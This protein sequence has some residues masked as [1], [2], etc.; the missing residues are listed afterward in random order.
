M[1]IF[2]V[3]AT[4]TY[5]TISSAITAAPGNND[6][7]IIDPGTYNEGVT[8]DKH[9]SLLG[10]TFT[11]EN[12]DVIINAPSSSYPINI[13]YAP[14]SAKSVFIEG[15]KLTRVLSTWSVDFLIT[16]SNSNLSV[17]FNRCII[18]AGTNEYSLDPNNMALNKFYVENCYLQRGY[19]HVVYGDWTNISESVISKTETNNAY[20]CYLCT[21]TPDTLDTV[22][23]PTN[24][25][26]PAYGSYYNSIPTGPLFDPNDWANRFRI[27]V[28]ISKVDEDLTDFPVCITLA[29]GVGISNYDATDIF[30]ELISISGTK[31]IAVVDES[32]NQLYTEIESW[33]WVNEKAV[34]WAKV[35]NI[36]SISGTVLYLYY[37]STTSGNTYYIGDT[38]DDAATYVWTNNYA[39]VWHMAQDPS[40]GSNCVLDSTYYMRHFTPNGSMDSNDLVAGKIGKAIEFDGSNDYLTSSYNTN[41]LPTGP[42]TFE[43]IIKRDGTQ[44]TWFSGYNAGDTE[45]WDMFVT[46][47]LRWY[48]F[49][50]DNAF[51][52]TATITGSEWTQTAFVY[53]YD[54]TSLDYYVNGSF[55]SSHTVVRSLQ[56]NANLSI[57]ARS[58]GSSS[59][60]N[61][62][63]YTGGVDE[64]RISLCERSAAWIKANYYSHW[65]DFITFG[66]LPPPLPPP[67][68]ISGVAN[69]WVSGDF[70]FKT[71][72]SGIGVYSVLS[73]NLLGVI[74][75]TPR[76]AGAVWANDDYL[77]ISTF[78]SGV[79]K[80]PMSSISGA[81][82]NDLSIYKNY[83]DINSECVSYIHGEDD[84]LCVA[85]LSGAHI[86][87]LTTH[88]GVY[89]NSSIVADKCFQ[90][91]NRTSYYIY[92]NNLKTVYNDNSTYLYTSGDGILP[93]ISGINDVYVVNDTIFLA[94]TSCAI[95]IEEN[96]GNETN[97]RFKYYYIEE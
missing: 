47:K 1:A 34:L 33:D 56:S 21:G 49:Q 91:G 2:R 72:V 54:S 79:L 51:E 93:T 13:N 5:T 57:A 46:T 28:D 61:T 8:I 26:G 74:D 9:V 43:G 81:I 64:F 53:D 41:N 20:Y 36:S 11:P 69:V 66:E 63:H 78:D 83:P 16:N 70:I 58:D 7:I 3:G 82:Y 68:T 89:T 52:S 80:S 14:G 29:S 32:Y 44:N 45:R 73:E 42:V 18:I 4:R 48:E 94:T 6:L 76:Y 60:G 87:D 62:Y 23:T 77:Y 67:P 40:G 30:D 65:D 97:S 31:N 24:G 37:D 12:G 92:E 10:N 88:S 96:K 71:M 59:G 75:Y 90:L 86:F 22:A 27:S 35:P 38:G 50:G 84:Y 19:A 15:V 25:Y 39:G 55:D 85:T 95:V 17:Y